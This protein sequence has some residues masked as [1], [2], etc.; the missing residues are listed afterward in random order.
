MELIR[1]YVYVVMVLA[2]MFSSP[3]EASAVPQLINFQ[4][5]IQ[6]SG[7]DYTGSGDFKFALVDKVGATTYWSMTEPVWKGQSRRMRCP[8]QFPMVSTRCSWVMR[9]WR[10]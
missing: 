10:T 6:V 8:S 7:A 1:I 3:D 4:G 5:R 2:A 9:P